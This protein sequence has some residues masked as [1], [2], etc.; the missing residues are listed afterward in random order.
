V[1]ATSLGKYNA[2]P[3]GSGTKQIYDYY[4]EVYG[5]QLGVSETRKTITAQDGSSVEIFKQ[6]GNNHQIVGA[7][8][9]ANYNRVVIVNGDA[10]ITGNI[11]Y[12]TA[13]VNNLSQLPQ[14][15][16]LAT[17]DIKIDKNVSQIDAWLIS[18][19]GNIIT[20]NVAKTDVNETNCGTE[21]K[22]N[23]PMIA[24]NIQS[25]RTAGSNPAGDRGAPAETYDLR[26]DSLLWTYGKSGGSGK[27]MTTYTKELAP[28]F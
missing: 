9:G 28:R 26:A 21:L 15:I 7:T 19:N 24:K 10:K 8:L 1:S 5:K 2:D 17:G 25:W 13:G 6:D 4:N 23:G 18:K 27:I 11:T 3:S 20:C 14:M 16:I 12:N 22:V